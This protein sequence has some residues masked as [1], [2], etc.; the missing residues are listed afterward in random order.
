MYA[1][2]PI[3]YPSLEEASRGDEQQLWL[4]SYKINMECRRFIEDRAM[5]AYNTRELDSFIEDLVQ[6]YGVERAMYVLSRT[7]SYKEWNGRFDEVVR[8]RAKGFDFPDTRSSAVKKALTQQDAFFADRTHGYITDI[9]PC[10]ANA[11]F[12]KLM[13]LENEQAETNITDENELSLDEDT[14]AEL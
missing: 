14:A 12:V 7:V 9:H 3:Y 8:E 5:T 1:T 6:D 10:V 2:I 11:V 13:E 4:D